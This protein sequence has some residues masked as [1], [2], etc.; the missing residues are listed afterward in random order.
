MQVAKRP[1]ERPELALELFCL[2]KRL[3]PLG[4]CRATHPSVGL[5][6]EHLFEK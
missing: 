4:S 3:R 2:L 6:R 5:G 1:Q